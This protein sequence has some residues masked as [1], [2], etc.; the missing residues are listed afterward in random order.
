KLVKA[1]QA[2]GASSKAVTC[3]RSSKTTHRYSVN[4]GRSLYRER[5]FARQEGKDGL[6]EN[7]GHLI[8]KRHH[9]AAI[10]I[11]DAPEIAPVTLPAKGMRIGPRR[12]YLDGTLHKRQTHF[13]SIS[14]DYAVSLNTQWTGLQ[15]VDHELVQQIMF[16]CAASVLTSD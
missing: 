11:M 5:I 14:I 13:H 16:A 12:Q 1:E 10:S 8:R 9:A 2:T 4:L 7:L 6:C 15:R 3:E